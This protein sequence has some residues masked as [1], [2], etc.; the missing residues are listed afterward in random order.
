MGIKFSDCVEKKFSEKEK[1]LVTNNF[2]FSHNV[3]KSCLLVMHQ[4]EYVWSKGITLHQTNLACLQYKS[5]E[6]SEGKG[7]TSNF[8]VLYPLGKF[9]LIF[10]NFENVI[11][12]LFPFVR[13]SNLSFQ[14]GLNKQL[15]YGDLHLHSWH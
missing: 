14:K 13:V 1:L 6:N 8:F 10:I 2:S 5:F 7:E 9:P 15:F 11:C 4:T 12:K 3:F